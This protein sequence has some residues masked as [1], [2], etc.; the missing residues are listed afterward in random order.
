MEQHRRLKW[1]ELINILQTFMCTRNLIQTLLIQPNQ[2][3]IGR[4]IWPN[5]LRS[6]LFNDLF[7]RLNCSFCNAFDRFPIMHIFAITPS[8]PKL[9]SNNAGIDLNQMA[10]FLLTAP[11]LS[12]TLG[13]PLKEGIFF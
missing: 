13:S 12:H 4:N 9:S 6:T 8:Q 3:E 1:R 5:S 11:R 2:R 10:P 7:K